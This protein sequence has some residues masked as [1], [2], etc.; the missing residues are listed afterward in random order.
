MK[1][2]K[3]IFIPLC[4][5]IW[6]ATMIISCKKDRALDVVPLDRVSDLSTW[7]DESTADV[8]LNDIYNSLPD[9]N[10][11]WDPFENWSDNSIC[12]FAWPN[13]IAVVGKGLFASNTETG[14][15][16]HAPSN[17]V[18]WNTLYTNIRKCNVFITNV[19]AS[20][21]PDSYK[22]KRLG[23]A[24]F[25][26]AFNYHYLWMFF[27]GVPIIT[28]PDNRVAD[29]DDIFHS[30]AT[31]DET[32]QFIEDELASISN[33]LPQNNDAGRITKGAALTLKGWV[34]LFYASQLYNT[35]DDVSRWATAAAT[36]KQVMELGYELYP[37]YRNLFI[38]V[39]N[40]NN[41]GIFYR[42]Y[43]PRVKG[44]QVE[45]FVGPRAV[46]GRVLSWGGL[47]PTQELVDDYNMDNGKSITDPT[48]GY[49]PLD[50]Y[51]SREPRFYESIMY[52]GS[53]Y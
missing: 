2:L 24:R 53:F 10:N 22:T 14:V 18:E 17:W 21:L 4:F 5:I 37:S 9:L 3:N 43:I 13:S 25:I 23:E 11:I 47:N 12:G 40:T 8:F 42:Q 49:N 32:Y 45:S 30:R 41:E 6:C 26:R 44:G 20:E 16:W 1:N 28:K 46:Q 50:P 52:D 33:D 34:E 51:A 7:T 35:S 36:N 27:G 38:S 19:E 29:G 39:G 31:F 15:S 48:S